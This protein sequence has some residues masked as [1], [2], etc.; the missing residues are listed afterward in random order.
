MNTVAYLRVSSEE[1]ARSG[2]GIDSQKTKIIEL[3]KEKKL[4]VGKFYLDNGL[5]GRLRERP[6][7]NGLLSDIENDGINNVL[8][9]SLDRLA[10]NLALSILIENEFKKHNIKLYTVME[11]SFDLDDPFQKFIK[12]TREGMA[13]LEADLARLRTEA[14]LRKKLARG[15]YPKGAAPL[16]FE[17]QGEKPHRTLGK[18]RGWDLVK[19]IFKQYLELKSLGKVQKVLKQKNLKTTRGKDFSRQT[20]VGILR[21]PIYKGKF[22]HSGVEGKTNPIIH[23]RIFNQVQ[24]TLE[25]KVKYRR[26]EERK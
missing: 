17:W 16:G 25:S 10:R 21:N 22:K 1:Q 3:A 5:S 24:R 26:E 9:Y 13:E 7:L 11:S 2:L 6:G 8:T 12:H 18:G 23:P 19:L 20:I 14:A 15:E 4:E